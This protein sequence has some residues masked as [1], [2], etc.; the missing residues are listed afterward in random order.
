MCRCLVEEV[1]LLWHVSLLV[2]CWGCIYEHTVLLELLLHGVLHLVL[3]LQ[4]LQWTHEAL[5][6]SC[7]LSKEL[8]PIFCGIVLDLREILHIDHDNLV[9]QS[10]LA[11]LDF[12][13]LLLY[14]LL[15][16][17][18]IA[19]HLGVTSHDEPLE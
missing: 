15:D 8:L 18:V 6:V 3:L 13:L 1:V 12:G 10:L 7:E 2:D 11:S 19:L 16:L 4:T 5:S 17:D 14:S 9:E